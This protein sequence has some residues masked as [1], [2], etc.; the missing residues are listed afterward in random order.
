MEWVVNG[1]ARNEMQKGLKQLEK[2]QKS[3]ETLI[4]LVLGEGHGQNPV[5]ALLHVDRQLKGGSLSLS[6][7][8]SASSAVIEPATEQALSPSAAVG[9]GA[10]RR[11]SQ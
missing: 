11:E 6:A 2:R 3:F 5:N 1:T 10:V 8:F 4:N 7:L 9:P